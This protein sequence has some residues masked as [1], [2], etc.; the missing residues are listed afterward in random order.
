[1]FY[2]SVTFIEGL[3]CDGHCFM[4]FMYINSMYSSHQSTEVGIIIIPSYRDR[5]R[6]TQERTNNFHVA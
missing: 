3:L 5:I 1:M 4:C 6:G 2:I